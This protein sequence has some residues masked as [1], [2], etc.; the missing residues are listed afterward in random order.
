[1]DPVQ[2][3]LMVACGLEGLGLLA[4]AIFGKDEE[5]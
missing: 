5:E 1:M 3:A 4:L 2:I